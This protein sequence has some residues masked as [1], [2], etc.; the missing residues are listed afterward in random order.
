MTRLWRMA[1]AGLTAA[2]VGLLAAELRPATAGPAAGV[3]GGAPTVAMPPIVFDAHEDTL[4]RVL[5][6]GDTLD[7]LV[8][9]GHGGIPN[10]RAGGVNAVWLA[11][12]V[13]PRKYQGEAAVERARKLIAALRKQVAPLP[14]HSRILH[15]SRRGEIGC[16]ARAHCRPSRC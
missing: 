12:W 16:R 8:A 5:D 1:A 13:D 9:D 15:N 14:R 4:R 2:L 11:A 3:A 6:R 7:E 10:W